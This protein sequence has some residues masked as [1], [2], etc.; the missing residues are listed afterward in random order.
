MNNWLKNNHLLKIARVPLLLFKHNCI[1]CASSTDQEHS[2]C[3][4]CLDNLPRVPKPCCPKCGLKSLGET[5]GNCLKNNPHYDAT[6]A[7]FSYAYPVD[8]ILQHYK[9]KNALYLSQTFGQLLSESVV[10]FDIDTVI[11]MPLHPI[12]LK[13]RG[14]N[15]S[16]EVAKIIAKQFNLELDISSCRR[17]KNTP[18]QASLALKDRTKNMKDA[19]DCTANFNGKHITIIDDV[20][21]T[22]AS[23]NELAKT[24]KRAGAAKVS[25]YVLARTE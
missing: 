17:I 15:Q 10:D 13:E 16:L 22:G 14:F 19:F 6:H 21:T 3:L 11:P 20:M 9:Y 23:L 25:C 18:P 12:R 2:L 24:L 1:L 8:A 4:N 5:C 7:L